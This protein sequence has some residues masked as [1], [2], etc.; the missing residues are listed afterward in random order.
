MRARQMDSNNDDLVYSWMKSLIVRYRATGDGR[1]AVSYN[2]LHNFAS[3][4][5]PINSPYKPFNPLKGIE[6]RKK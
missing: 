2:R 3:K 6:T 1:P 4:S 5:K